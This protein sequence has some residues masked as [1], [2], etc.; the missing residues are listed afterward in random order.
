[1]QRLH[2]AVDES[3]C[4]APAARWPI[5]TNIVGA[6][7]DDATVTCRREIPA[8]TL[9]PAGAV[10][11]GTIAGTDDAPCEA[12]YDRQFDV[13]FPTVAVVLGTVNCIPECPVVSDV[14]ATP[15]PL[16]NVA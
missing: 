5:P 14:N 1:M 2:L 13:P 10:Y 15:S 4:V 12:R 11:S 9:P 8:S 6:V 16:T 3:H 7:S